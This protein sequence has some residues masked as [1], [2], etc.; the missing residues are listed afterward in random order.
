MDSL[1][2]HNTVILCMKGAWWVCAVY[3]LQIWG[4]QY[5]HLCFSSPPTCRRSVKRISRSGTGALRDV[6]TPPRGWAI[7]S[8]I[9]RRLLLKKRKNFTAL[10]ISTTFLKMFISK[11]LSPIVRTSKIYIFLMQEIW[12]SELHLFTIWFVLVVWP[13]H[14]SYWGARIVVRPYFHA[15]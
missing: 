12:T 13:H 7:Q 11:L 14:V 4:L 1:P 2:V 5:R 10:L 3:N 8:S 15:S 6:P 9:S